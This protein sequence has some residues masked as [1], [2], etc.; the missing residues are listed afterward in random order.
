MTSVS[1]ELRATIDAYLHAWLQRCEPAG[2]DGPGPVI[3]APARFRPRDARLGL[4]IALETLH[5]LLASG[6][7]GIGELATALNRSPRNARWVIAEHPLPTGRR[8]EVVDWARQV[9]DIP[10]VALTKRVS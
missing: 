10:L 7:T 8:T 5:S 9:Q 4:D 6:V 2:P 1:A 3:W